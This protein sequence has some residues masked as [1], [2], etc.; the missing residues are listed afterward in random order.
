[1]E[2]LLALR[3]RQSGVVGA[4][5]TLVAL[6]VAC[7]PAQEEPIPAGD[8]A[9]ACETRSTWTRSLDDNCLKCVAYAQSPSCECP[10][11]NRFPMAAACERQAD[12]RRLES[13]CTVE[14]SK[15]VAACRASD[16]ACVAACFAGAD[17]CKAAVG[18]LDSC[19]ADACTSLC[20]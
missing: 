17:A 18:A 9:A 15:C 11:I 1:M 7:A 20:K 6:L 5:A 8:V 14:R 19:V 2:S 16:C 3:P 13:T 4:F 10:D 12:A